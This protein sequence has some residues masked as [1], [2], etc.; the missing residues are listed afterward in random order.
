M[1]AE[2]DAKTTSS[3]QARISFHAAAEG[4]ARQKRY[5]MAKG[6]ELRDRGS[7][8]QE[9]VR[10]ERA[11]MKTG[12]GRESAGRPDETGIQQGGRGDTTRKP[13]AETEDGKPSRQTST[14]G[15]MSGQL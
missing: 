12:Y 13:D 9:P 1:A 14:A 10:T 7:M 5:A 4:P 6:P 15:D 3:A 11:R 8:V 2:F